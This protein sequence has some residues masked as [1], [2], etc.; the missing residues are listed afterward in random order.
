MSKKV[1]EINDL[2]VNIDKTEILKNVSLSV[3][4]G[5][6]VGLLGP[7][8]AGKTTL[9]KSVCGL[10]KPASG[11]IHILDYNVVNE[12]CDALGLVGVLIEDTCAYEKLSG[13]ENLKILAR[14]YGTCD[15][16]QIE[17]IVDIIGLNDSINNAF[18]TYSLGMK[19]RL[20]IGMALI[21][22][23]K[24]LILDEPSNGLDIEGQH[25]ITALIKKLTAEKN[26]SIIISSHITGQLEKVCQS[27]VFVKKGKIIGNIRLDQVQE[28]TLEEY[29]LE[30][31]GV[32]NEQIIN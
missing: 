26:M 30:T 11:T 3:N 23:P 18:K 6:V 31:M 21:N 14:M 22:N 4:E 25:E 19:K 10:V 13:L 27:V 28:K 7:N 16:K 32:K 2:N 20:G 9:M 12:C 15:E 1:I 8:G 29:Y 24:I 17:E 5:E